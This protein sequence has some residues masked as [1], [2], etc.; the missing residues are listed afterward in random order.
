[1]SRRRQPRYPLKA[2]KAAFSD[3]TRL[4]RTMTAADGAE[5][6]GWTSTVIDVVT[7]LTGREASCC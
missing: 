1:V 3:A 7:G 5:D 4:N 6:L 2:I